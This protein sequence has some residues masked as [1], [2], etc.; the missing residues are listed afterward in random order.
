MK[1]IIKFTLL[2]FIAL[3]ISCN[4]KSKRELFTIT[5]TFIE[6]LSTTYESYGLLGG[7][8]EVVLTTDGQYQVFPTGRLIIV[9]IMHVA[10]DKE[11]DKLMKDL[12][13][14]YK[15]NKAVNDVYRNQAG[16][17]VVDCRN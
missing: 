9:K 8:D 12:K 2:I 11:Y 1:T 14:R 13:R 7:L 6:S 10:T 5:D 3:L 17:L 15:N 4:S 16:T